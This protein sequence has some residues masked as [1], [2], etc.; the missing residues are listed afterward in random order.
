VPFS[1]RTMFDLVQ[2]FGS[3]GRMTK[4]FY[5]FLRDRGHFETKMKTAVR[6]ELK[7]SACGHFFKNVRVVRRCRTLR[8]SLDNPTIILD[9]AGYFDIRRA[10]KISSHT[11][12]FRLD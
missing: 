9:N 5:I 7:C 1:E 6:K 2:L 10:E 8:T 3:P 4:F 12:L 11:R